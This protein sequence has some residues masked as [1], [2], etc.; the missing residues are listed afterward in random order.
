[1]VAVHVAQLLKDPVGSVRSV[2]FE[3]SSE[4]LAAA[5]GLVGSIRGQVKLLRTPRGILVEG[6]YHASVSVECGR[7][8]EPVALD[9]DGELE[10][11]FAPTVN[12]NTGLPAPADD[13]PETPL[14]GADHI[15]DLD[16]VLRQDIT[17]RL[18]MQPLCSDN[19]RGLC[20][21][22]GADLNTGAC[23]CAQAA[24]SALGE[25]QLSRLGELLKAQ[26]AGRS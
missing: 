20:V 1:M 14:I 5:V 24:D 25:A 8:L 23:Q 11:E 17:V 6:A 9:V 21:D 3:E 7:C 10:Q 22:C 16:D 4:L 13:E 26:L 12:V 18:P 2:S 15:L 19:C